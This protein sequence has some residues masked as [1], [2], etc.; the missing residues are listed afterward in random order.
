[1]ELNLTAFYA[2]AEEKDAKT[3]GLEMNLKLREVPFTPACL[4][5][6]AAG[7]ERKAQTKLRDS[8]SRCKR[9][10]RSFGGRFSASDAEKYLVKGL[11]FCFFFG[12]AKKE[13]KKNK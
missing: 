6:S 7:D 12:G 4:R 2:Y 1:V 11:F 3:S 8:G 5:R 10:T 9:L 13:K